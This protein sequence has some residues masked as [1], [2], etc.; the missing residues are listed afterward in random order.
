MFISEF[1]PPK[2]RG[3][4]VAFYQLSIVL[5]ILLAYL[6]NWLL[7]RFAQLH[8]QGFD[9]WTTL[10]RILVSEYWRGMFGA[11]M[12]PAISFLLLL[13][14]V[15]ESPRWLIQ[16]GRESRGL[17]VLKRISTEGEAEM[18]LAEIKSSL[19]LE[20]GS[21]RE[22]FRPNLRGALVLGVMLSVF[23]QL[24]GVNI[25]VYYGPKILMAAG[26]HDAGALL[27]QVGFGLIN[28]VFTVLA[29]LTIDRWGR[30]PLLVGGMGAVTLTL[31]AI[32]GLFLFGMKTFRDSIRCRRHRVLFPGRS[33]SGSGF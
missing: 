2:W 21:I 20:R 32:G 31:A 15:P 28:L 12:L 33:A 23:G 7:L 24:S 4:L 8:P 26:F 13:F 22:L 18:Q 19:G 16:A 5:G 27:A 10:H 29:L 1:A 6:S 30:R 14:C 3:R 11:E 25:V 9:G 17:Y